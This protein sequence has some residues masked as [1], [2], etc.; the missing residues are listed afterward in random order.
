M[1]SIMVADMTRGYIPDAAN[2]AWCFKC[3]AITARTMIMLM[4]W[5][6]I[7]GTHARV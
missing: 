6:T 1:Y 4:G 7:N 3:A 2:E 5:D